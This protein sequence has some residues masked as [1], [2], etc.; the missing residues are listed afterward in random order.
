MW[1]RTNVTKWPCHPSL[2]WANL[3]ALSSWSFSEPLWFELLPVL[4]FIRHCLFF[5]AYLKSY[6]IKLKKPFFWRIIVELHF[7]LSVF[8]GV[9]LMPTRDQITLRVLQ[10]LPTSNLDPRSQISRIFQ[11]SAVDNCSFAYVQGLAPD[12][13]NSET[14]LRRR[15]VFQT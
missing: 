10:S 2:C 8:D 13:R 5:G 15:T 1:L 11:K 14:D 12:Q 3:D 6:D 7:W 9:V 4:F